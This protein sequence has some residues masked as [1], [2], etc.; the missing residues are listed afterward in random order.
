MYSTS[1]VVKEVEL[2][3]ATILKVGYARNSRNIRWDWN[4]QSITVDHVVIQCPAIFNELPSLNPDT[5]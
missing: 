4:S 5:L 3:S 1:L 2:D